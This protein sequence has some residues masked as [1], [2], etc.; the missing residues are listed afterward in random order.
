VDVDADAASFTAWLTEGPATGRWVAF[1]G[2]EITGHIMV[3]QPHLYLTDFLDAR[4][5]KPR[6]AGGFL[7][8][9]KFFVDPGAQ[10]RG[11]GK[12]LFLHARSV[13]LQ[14]N[15]R[16]VLAVV[17]T[18]VEARDF[19]TRHGMSEVGSFSGKHGKNLVFIDS[20]P[21]DEEAGSARH[22]EGIRL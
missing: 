18:S 5:I 9:G 10:R 3:V 14:N 16:A 7:E 20:F 6:A 4:S 21:L 11:I 22:S 15:S 2:D 17:E 8:I 19:Y 13:I 1:D 12:A